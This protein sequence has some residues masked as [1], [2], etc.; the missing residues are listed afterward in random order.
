MQNFNASGFCSFI[1]NIFS[2][3]MIKFLSEEISLYLKGILFSF[4]N[5]HDGMRQLET[6]VVQKFDVLFVEISLFLKFASNRKK[7]REF[8][9]FDEDVVLGATVTNNT[10]S[11][12]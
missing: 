3:K 2:I 10:I 1:I 9:I 6:E 5:L 12:L 7:F 4:D 11:L 8:Q